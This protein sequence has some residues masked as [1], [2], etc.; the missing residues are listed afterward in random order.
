VD[1]LLFGLPGTGETLVARAVV[2]NE[3]GAFFFLIRGP[4]I[5]K[6]MAGESESNFRKVFEEAEKNSPDIIFIDE[7]D[8]IAPKCEKVRRGIRPVLQMTAKYDIRPT[9]KSSIVSSRNC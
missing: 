8:S 4:E 9:E 5:V 1:I 3:T 2:A 6:K 7:I